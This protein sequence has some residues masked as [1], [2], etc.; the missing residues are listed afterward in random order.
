MPLTESIFNAAGN[1]L[2][3]LSCRRDRAHARKGEPESDSVMSMKLTTAS[4]CLK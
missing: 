2:H 3:L 1:W 4:V